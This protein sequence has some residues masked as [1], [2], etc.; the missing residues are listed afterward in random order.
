[1]IP[2]TSALRFLKSSRTP[3]A[4]DFEF[5]DSKQY[6]GSALSA[7]VKW[8]EG[9][10]TSAI[11]VKY[12]DSDDMPTA[13]GEYT[14]KVTTTKDGGYCAANDLNIG[15]FTIT[16]PTPTL[17]SVTGATSGCQGDVKTYTANDGASGAAGIAISKYIWALPAGWNGSSETS[18]ISA[19]LGASGGQV[20]CQV[21][22]ACGAKSDVVPSST[23]SV[24]ATASAGTVSLSKTSMCYGD[25]VPTA[26]VDGAVLG[27]GSATWSS[28]DESVATI[29]SDGTTITVLKAGTTNI[30]Y[31]ITGGC[32]GDKSDYKTLTVNAVPVA[33][34]VGASV[35]SMCPDGSSELSATG[36]SGATSYKW[37]KSTTSATEGFTD[38]SGATSATYTASGLTAGDYW[39]RL[40]V[41]GAGDC[42]NTSNA[43]KVTVNAA[44]SLTL[45]GTSP[46]G[47]D[48]AATYPWEYMTITATCSVTPTWDLTGKPAGFTEDV[49]YVVEGSDK[50]YKIKA[51]QTNNEDTDKFT[52]TVT[53][54][55]N[56]CST[57]K[58]FDVYIN[59]A[60][61]EVCGD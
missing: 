18:T 28:S 27:G 19:T 33:G 55:D 34:T 23:V 61:A 56:G 48:V 14:L 5:E 21:Q 60:P 30:T 39:F 20:N 35:A 41:S 29:T 8:R 11:T 37:Q 53:A 38:I 25:A 6:T 32:G 36:T 22:N 17:T 51:K 45:L 16:C 42:S 9:T 57:V 31:T 24:N 7:D 54:T 43:V 10:G 26:S 44:P 47:T 49:D 46:K 59:A 4:S 13:A 58:T 3:K 12:N 15:T 1:M 40:V 50:V 52:F 2:L